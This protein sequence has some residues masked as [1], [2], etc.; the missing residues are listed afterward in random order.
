[1]GKGIKILAGL[2]ILTII[3]VVLVISTI[4]VNEY[5][6]DLVQ[7]VEEA[8]GRK[9]VIDG[10]IGFAI[11]LIPTVVI[12]DVKFA[13]ASWGSKPDMLS[14][15]RFEVQV[16]L[17]PLLSG[18]IQINRVI[19]L[20]P[21]IFLETDKNGT[22]NWIF[23]DVEETSAIV[24]S[25]PE[26][27]AD[28]KLPGIVINEIQ[29]ENARISYKDGVTG[30]ETKLVAEKITT[31]SSSFEEPFSLWAKIIYDETPIQIEGTMGALDHLA[32]NDNYPLDINISLN[33]AKLGL[34]GYVAKPLSGKGF[35]LVL[36]FNIDSLS[37]L[38][39]LA[40]NELPDIG[41]ISLNGTL[42]D[43]ENSYSLKAMKLQAGKT[44]LSGDLTINISGERP[45][46]S[47]TLIANMIDLIELSGGESKPDKKTKNER[48]FSADPLPL[49]SMRSANADI[50]INA[51][52][53]QTSSLVLNNTKISLTLKDG[54]LTIKP[55][56]AQIAGGNLNGSI[57]L[58][59]RG[60]SAILTTDI[61]IK[62]LEPSQLPDLDAKVTG[63][64]TDLSI[65]IKG[66]GNSVS[67]I[68]AGLDGKLL[69]KV[70]QGVI[71]DT[72]SNIASADILTKSFSM[73]MPGTSTNDNAQLECGVANFD[74][75][76]GIATT[77]KGIALAT[78]K[79]NVIGSGTID[80]KT[81]K[82]D[83][84][85]VPEAREGIGISVGQLAGLVKL[86][87]TLANPKPETDTKAALKAGVSV[88][89][90]V[91]TGGLSIL[92]QGLFDRAT[93][94]ADP[95]ATALGEKQSK[96][97]ASSKQT[98]TTTNK[99]AET[100][101]GTGESVTDKI[102]GFFE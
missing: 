50:T 47:A 99:N 102:R 60:K 76:D 84:G 40:G 86:G 11:S 97:K 101:K 44:D 69:V 10:E 38:S 19:L 91:A 26:S 78:N 61:Q 31:E 62:G 9:L 82:L 80:L 36:N 6:S 66:S 83:I 81:E 41:P 85:I 3:V 46:I 67:K 56:S 54:D 49:E 21:D 72:G 24:G 39:R 32:A 7:V 98:E 88:G 35:D 17:I 23:K 52:Q 63:A 42:S 45:A 20:E 37:K 57:G 79:M 48:V 43:S 14:L 12:E 65:N 8:T 96:P 34:Q 16:S 71:K 18:N 68:M 90:A 30:K 13:N 33:E 74:I 58:D 25:D 77:K 5:K 1:M 94:D 87:G 53:I 51:K 4:D 29:I 64:K 59:A 89:A 100:T 27:P 73:L 22:G 93:A 15:N 92:A 75:K 70:G 95:C 2:F 55:L 28:S